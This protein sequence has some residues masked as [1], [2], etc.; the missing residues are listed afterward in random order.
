MFWNHIKYHIAFLKYLRHDILEIFYF[1]LNDEDFNGLTF[2]NELLK[3]TNDHD[4]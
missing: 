2:K 4:L 3:Y 1:D